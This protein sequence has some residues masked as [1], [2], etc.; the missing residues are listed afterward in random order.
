MQNRHTTAIDG[1]SAGYAGAVIL[2][3]YILYI[4]SAIYN[5]F[6]TVRLCK[7]PTFVVPAKETVQK[8]NI[9]HS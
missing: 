5:G 4:S 8:L 7:K 2:C 9:R 3:P 6:A 1:G